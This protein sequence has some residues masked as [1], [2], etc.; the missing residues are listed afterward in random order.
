ME[1]IALIVG[2]LFIALLYGGI[3]A[4]IEIRREEKREYLRRRVKLYNDRMRALPCE[5]KR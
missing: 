4:A 1:N 5:D 3:R 2:L